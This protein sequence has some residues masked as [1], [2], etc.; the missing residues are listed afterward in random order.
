MFKRNLEFIESEINQVHNTNVLEKAV[1]RRLE[2]SL[3]IYKENLESTW[4]YLVE[5]DVRTIDNFLKLNEK[6]KR[7]EKRKN[8]ESK[9]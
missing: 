5:Q 2:S 3:L 4:K 8:K 9:K 1:K 7:Q 6:K